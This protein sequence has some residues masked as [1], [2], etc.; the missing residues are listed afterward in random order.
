MNTVASVV[1][2]L[3]KTSSS[4]QTKST[5]RLS[6]PR[7]SPLS[8][9]SA[10]LKDLEQSRHPRTKEVCDTASFV[11][12]LETFANVALRLMALYIVPNAGDRL[13]DVHYQAV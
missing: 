8:R 12:R 1:T 9:A 7:A 6:E 5:N 13:V 2:G 3:W 11:T 4:E 10:T